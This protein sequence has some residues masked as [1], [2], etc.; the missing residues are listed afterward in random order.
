MRFG[1]DVLLVFSSGDQ[2][3]NF[4]YLTNFV[5]SLG[6]MWG[7]MSAP[8]EMKCILNFHWELEEARQKSGLQD[9]VGVFDPMPAVNEALYAVGGNN[10]GVIGLDRMPVLAFELIKSHNQHLQFL[11]ITKEINMARRVKS[12]FELQNLRA[13]VEAT[14]QVFETL[15]E[16]LRPGMTEFDVVAKIVYEFNIRGVTELAFS[17]LVMGGNDKPVMVREPSGRELREGDTVLVDIGGVVEG[18]QA[19]VTRTF[20]L[21]EP[22]EEQTRIWDTI[23]YAHEAVLELARPGVPCRAL[24][25][26]AEQIIKDAGYEL[27]HRIGHGIGLATSFEW[28]SLDTETG[29]LLPGMTIAIEPGI[30]FPGAGSMKLEDSLVI[31]DNGNEVLSKCPRHL[32]L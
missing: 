22:T 14:D 18:Y 10:V 5:P 23:Q 15:R 13:A 2:P 29:E 30:Y 24:H 27:V 4:R 16:A 19:D 9:W 26:A 8:E 12:S 28:P 6:D 25:H 32:A 20:V 1:C 11:D 31:T 7:V 21:G 17:P 3:Q